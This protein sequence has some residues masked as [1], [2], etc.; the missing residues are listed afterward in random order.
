MREI[1]AA[2][3]HHGVSHYAWPDRLKFEKT[4]FDN[5]ICLTVEIR[6]DKFVA[7]FIM[8]C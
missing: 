7:K 8:Q 3:W 4:A 5:T 2:S 1:S 6:M